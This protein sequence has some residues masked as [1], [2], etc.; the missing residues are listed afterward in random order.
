M[1]DTILQHHERLD[2]SGYPKGLTD[3]EI[4]LTS[5]ILAVAD[6]VEAML[7][8]R[9][10]RRARDVEEAMEEI[11]SNSGKLYDSLVV[12]SCLELFQGG[13]SFEAHKE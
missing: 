10:H 11:S 3:K 5:K 9:P 8:D 2:G 7:S 1:L 4:L 12:K 13:F 6:V